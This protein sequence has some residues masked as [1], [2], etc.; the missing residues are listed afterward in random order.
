MTDSNDNIIPDVG[1][2]SIDLTG[3][4]MTAVQL[5]AHFKITP[6]TIVR[7]AERPNFP[8]AS[9]SAGE[10][11]WLVTDVQEWN[12]QR[13]RAYRAALRAQEKAVETAVERARHRQRLIAA[14][15]RTCPP[16][17]ERSAVPLSGAP[18]SRKMIV[19]ADGS[20]APAPSE[21]HDRRTMPKNSR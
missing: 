10:A 19:Q 14:F 4:Y 7:W 1:P 3:I 13:K 2:P 15:A 11:A 20:L 12:R 8:C 21:Q 6:A 18:L 9:T 17:V 16:Q 5:A